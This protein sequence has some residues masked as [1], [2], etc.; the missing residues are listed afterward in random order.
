MFRDRSIDLTA[1]ERIGESKSVTTELLYFSNLTDHNFRS[2]SIRAGKTSAVV[3]ESIHACFLVCNNGAQPGL[4]VFDVPCHVSPLG[5]LQRFQLRRGLLR[6][7]LSVRQRFNA[8][9]QRDLT[10]VGRSQYGFHVRRDD[11]D[12]G[13]AD[14]CSGDGELDLVLADG[15]GV[16]G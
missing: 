2:T 13:F 8:V 10:R 3:S 6:Q 1:D 14:F 7:R 15:F 16:G 4:G 9:F 11:S 5:I 12:A